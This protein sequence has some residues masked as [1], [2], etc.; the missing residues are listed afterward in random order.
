[1]ENFVM[2][3][4]VK[5]HFGTGV[6]DQIGKVTA[7]YGKNVLLVIGKGSVKASG[8]YDKVVSKL[9]QAGLTIHEYQGIKPNPVI[10][11][12]DK[13]AALGKQHG[14][15]VIV[16]LGG[17]SV[18]DS[19]KII[20]LAMKYDG[21]A[22]D[23]MIEKHTPT[24]AIPLI[25]VLTLAATGTEMN[26]VAVVQNTC[27]RQKVGYGHDLA[28]P[29]H[30]F[31]DPE[32]T[33][34]VPRNYTAWGVVDLVAHCLEVWFG[35]GQATL[36]DRFIISIM[37]EGMK[38]GPDLI[39]DLHNIDLRARIMFAA[40]CAL[41]GMT[42]HGK[43]GGDWAVHRIGHCLSV[44]HDTPHGA[45][46]SIV[47]PAWFK[48]MKERAHDRIQVLGTAL[49]E[50]SSIDDI[51]F[52]FEHFFRIMES[53]VHLKDVGIDVSIPDVREKI[54]KTM[55]LNKVT[56]NHYKLVEEDY[57]RLLDLMA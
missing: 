52:K 1:M 2:Y 17:G 25:S 7:Q 22:W 31:L 37:K 8:A 48:L 13:A 19:A 38:Y 47:Y 41:N 21:P 51:I 43:K 28:F 24:D 45:S 56:G 12:V 36:S 14:V 26:S 27:Q 33:V 23:I 4:P 54:R 53:P 11:D 15:D 32:F 46:L 30:S 42:S 5:V 20:A 34:T 9:Q 35:Q 18:I 29:K 3:N 49:F 39:N 40:T 50:T 44:I 55:V 10:E 57:N 6:T 16:A